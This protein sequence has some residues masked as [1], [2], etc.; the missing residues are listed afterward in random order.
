LK[1]RV[2]FFATFREIF[3]AKEREITLREGSTIEDVLDALC[4]S[5]NL[6]QEIFDNNGL[7][8]YLI[9]LKNDRHIQ[10]Q[11]GLKTEVQEGDNIA[12]FPLLDGG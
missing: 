4:N 9:I 7:K 6:R 5:E 3:Q 2:E 1:I 10:F 8:P 12:I 11:Q